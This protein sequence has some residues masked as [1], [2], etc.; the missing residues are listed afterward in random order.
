ME[1]HLQTR[2]SFLLGEIFLF[3]L[4]QLNYF[5][6]LRNIIEKK[7]EKENSRGRLSF[8]SQ[9]RCF[10]SSEREQILQPFSREAEAD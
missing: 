5:G 9:L 6:G 7:K 10:S 2:L 1:R 8:G 3:L 4:F